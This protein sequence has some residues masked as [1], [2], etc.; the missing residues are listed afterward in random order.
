MSYSSQLYCPH[1]EQFVA[2]RTYRR[3]RSEFYDVSKGTWI[4]SIHDEC[5][6]PPKKPLHVTTVTESSTKISCP[7]FI[8][9][10]E[11]QERKNHF[12]DVKEQRPVYE[13]EDL[14]SIQLDHVLPFIESSVQEV[15]ED[16]LLEDVNADLSEGR[17][18]NRVQGHRNEDHTNVEVIARWTVHFISS[19]SVFY[20]VSATA[21]GYLL[22]FFHAFLSACGLIAP[23]LLILSNSIPRSVYTLK[24]TQ[25]IL[26]DD[27]LKY[28]V[29]S[30]C[31]EL[32][33]LSEAEECRT[34]TFIKYPNHAQRKFRQK[35]G[36]K[37]LKEVILQ[38]G[39][40]KHYPI[41]IYCYRSVMKSIQNLLDRPG[42]KQRCE[43]W[44]Q[45]TSIPVC[46]IHL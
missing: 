2:D 37:L 17:N 15:W 23:Y 29:C 33:T 26:E 27:F 13:E 46:I 6:S 42:L 11:D 32:Y 31:N 30:K 35:C 24:K 34:C 45:R 18:V 3:H 8:D 22:T 7:P 41:K 44:R 16:V 4:R 19:W 21:L 40:R 5:C 36:E 39:S 28:V 14:E 20:N 12:L 43:D 10:Y 1:C 38:D 25:G 9:E